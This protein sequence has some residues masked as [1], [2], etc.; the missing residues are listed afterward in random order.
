MVDSHFGTARIPLLVESEDAPS[1]V[2]LPDRNPINSPGHAPDGL[3]FRGA[4]SAGRSREGRMNAPLLRTKLCVPPVR[5]ALVPRPRLIER[6]N[7]GRHGRLT[8]ISAPAGFGKTTLLSE[9]VSDVG[10]AIPHFGSARVDT[11]IQNLKSE[12]QNRV[13]WLSLDEGDNDLA[14]FLTYLLAALRTIPSLEQADVGSSVLAVLQSPGLTGVG[15]PFNEG[16]LTDLINDI[17]TADPDPFLLILDDYHEIRASSI[18]NALTFLLDHQ[19]PQM[20]LVIATR[21]DPP[22][23]TARLRGRGQL[24]ELRL[25][26]LRF[27]PEEAAGF[28]N[29]VMGLG[30]SAGDVAALVSRTEGWIAGLQMAAVSMQGREDVAAFVQAFAGSNRY[31]LDYLVEEVLQRQPEAVQAFLLQTAVLSRLTGPLCDAVLCR[32]ADE[33][34]SKG[35]LVT[36]GPLSPGASACGQEV[37]EYLERANL[38]VVPLDDRREWY[39]YHRLFADLLRKRLHQMQPDRVPILHRRASGWYECNRLM[40]PAIDHA[41]SADDFARAADLI[42]RVAEATL[43]RSEVTTL[44]RWVESLPD[45]LVR[46]RP[47]LCVY[48]AYALLLGGRS[49]DKVEARLRDAGEDSEPVSG[50]AAVLRA[51]V[52]IFQGQLPR[53]VELSQQALE[54]LPEGDAFL[55]SMA[56]WILSLFCLANGDFR[57]GS[58]ALDEVVRT[59]Q[60]MGN[61]MVAVAAMC[62]LAKLRSRRGRLYE[63]KAIYERALA[64]ATDRQGQPLPIASEPLL[65]LGELCREWN[66]LEAATRYLVEGIELTKR[67]SEAAALDAYLPLALV[68]QAQGDADGARDAIAMAWHL[69]L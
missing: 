20:H 69:A 67:W 36:A 58:R 66:D 4:T 61:V 42:E 17:A 34:G 39:R 19:P 40:A 43:M 33:Q 26:D 22:L 50:Q 6:L 25:P 10:C 28:L 64:L 44:L 32:G 27:T 46:A 62:N 51:L 11:P 14:R 47:A 31:I 55:R 3:G 57:A 15:V 13:A 54:R 2:V 8:L 30:L 52:A 18:H 68:R 7:A 59:S 37:L 24:T 29:Q 12:I 53:A 23:P 38:F 41:L 56:A 5:P 35:D 60:E 49:L 63:A 48:H 1:F 65:G 9:W 45:E 16:L 21:A